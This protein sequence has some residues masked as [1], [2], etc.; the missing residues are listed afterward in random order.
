MT[1]LKNIPHGLA[2]VLSFLIILLVA[3]CNDA[4]FEETV[5]FESGTDGYNTFRIPSVIVAADGTVLAFC[6]GRK[7]SMG[8]TGDIDIVLKKA[9]T[10]ALH[11]VR[12]RLYGMTAK[13]CVG[14][15]ARL[16]T[17]IPERYGC[18]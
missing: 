9:M 2:C 17:A 15:R 12:W 3:G 5:V 18:F 1:E 10:A 8:D 13:M 4:T 11:G 14:I 16:L 7:E 6:E